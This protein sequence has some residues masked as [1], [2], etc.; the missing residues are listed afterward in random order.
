MEK[1]FGEHI[2][3]VEHDMGAY[4]LDI[5]KK[6]VVVGTAPYIKDLG[7]VLTP[8]GRRLVLN[9]PHQEGNGRQVH[10]WRRSVKVKRW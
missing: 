6:S 10:R 2:V 9:N 8:E 1:R 7:T 4:T 3:Y 5:V